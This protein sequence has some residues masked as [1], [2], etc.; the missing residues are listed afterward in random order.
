MY[1]NSRVPDTAT[2]NSPANGSERE[3]H[4][5]ADHSEVV[6]GTAYEVPAEITDPA[7]MR[8]EADF[9]AAAHL[10][11]ALRLSSRET[12]CLDNVEAFPW[13]NDAH[14][15]WPLTTTEDGPT[16]SKN[17]RRKPC[18]R[19]WITQCQGA[20]CSTDRVGGAASVARKN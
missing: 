13:F 10:A 19:N 5:C 20:Q 4:A 17:V 12:L 14:I 15:F 3:V 11:Q 1:K 8:C 18:A 7:D 6:I 9:D 16:A 2:L